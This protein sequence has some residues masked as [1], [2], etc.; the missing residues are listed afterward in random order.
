M[1][2]Y[3]PDPRECW[4][5]CSRVSSEVRLLQ[6][7]PTGSGFNRLVPF[8]LLLPFTVLL[9]SEL[10]GESSPEQCPYKAGGSR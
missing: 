4:R 2:H 7:S 5:F 6:A 9:Q 3:E 1:I 8:F 10:I